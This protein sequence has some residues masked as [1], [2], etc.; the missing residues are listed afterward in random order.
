LTFTTADVPEYGHSGR[1]RSDEYAI[2]ASELSGRSRK[3]WDGA[4]IRYTLAARR[5]TKT[6]QIVMWAS[7]YPIDADHEFA[8]RR[9]HTANPASWLAVQLVRP[10]KNGC[11]ALIGNV[12]WEC[13]TT[14]YTIV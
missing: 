5:L 8:T 1:W 9:L 11:D 6:I 10:E 4:N 13:L 14:V 2:D 7:R 12:D 3:N